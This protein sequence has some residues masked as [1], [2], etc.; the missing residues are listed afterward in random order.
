VEVSRLADEFVVMEAAPKLQSCVTD[1]F[2]AIKP[3]PGAH[4]D[5]IVG[6]TDSMPGHP[7]DND[8]I[9]GLTKRASRVQPLL[10]QRQ[11]HANNLPPSP[12]ARARF[13]V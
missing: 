13:G 3:V 4:F 8:K 2:V 1:D 12:S 11:P 7:T 10:P 5:N 6:R 9:I